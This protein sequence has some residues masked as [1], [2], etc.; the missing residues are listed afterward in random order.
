[1]RPTAIAVRGACADA[2]G[3]EVCVSHSG[4]SSLGVLKTRANEGPPRLVEVTEGIS[5][6]MAGSLL[7]DLHGCPVFECGN[8]QFSPGFF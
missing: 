4:V 3:A 6:E 8:K 5:H 2:E 1:M 7:G